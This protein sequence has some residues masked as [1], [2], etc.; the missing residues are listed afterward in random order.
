MKALIKII[1]GLLLLVVLLVGG[2][3]VAL[4]TV[5]PNAYKGQL[6]SAVKE[7]TGRDLSIGG[8]ISVAFYPVLGF[9]A[10]GLE[11][12]NPE[13]FSGNDFVKAGEVQ[14][15]VNIMPLLKKKIEITTVRLVEPQI[16][17]IKNAD[18]KTNL[19]MPKKDVAAKAETPKLD[20]SVEGIEVSKA[21]VIYIDKATGKTT[22]INPLNLKIP[23]YASGRDIDV[24]LDMVVQNSAPAKPMKF[25]LSATVKPDLGKGE[26]TLRN[27]RANIDMGGAKASVTA[28]V[29]VNTKSE[30]IRISNLETDWQDTS[31]KGNATVKGFKEPAVTFD[32]SSPSVD[33]D[34]LMP[35]KPGQAKD[36]NKQL[37]PVDVLRKLSLDGKVAI[38]SLKTAGL[39]L[40]NVSVPVKAKGGIINLNPLT[41]NMY[42]GALSSHIQIDARNNAPAFSLKGDLKALEMGKLLTAK[43]GQDYLTGVTNV[44]F[45]LNSR[46]NTMN[47]LN[48]HSGGEIS[49]DFGKGY[50][51]KWQLSRLLNQAIAYFET[52]KLDQAADDKVYFTSLDGTFSGQG[53][54]FR[55]DNLVLIGP[56]SHALGSGSVNLGVQTVDYVVRVGGGDN[57]EKFAKKK[58]LPVRMTGP[59][60]K[61]SYSIDMQALIQ[62]VAG[63]K[64]EEKKQELMDGLF[65]KLDK[66]M[67]K[68]T[69]PTAAAPEAG[70]VTET[71]PAPAIENAPVPVEA[72]PTAEPAPAAVTP[73]AAPAEPVPAETPA[74]EAPENTPAEAVPAETAPAEVAPDAAAP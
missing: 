47:A 24:V 51:N 67:N 29:I 1:L 34:A 60:S 57:P 27:A 35:K 30:E 71:T 19:E 46:G 33:L 43:M 22:T 69:E 70:T 6:S 16:T 48:S 61:P 66:K 31:I 28:G 15:G 40:T 25:D 2:A 20:M 32:V 12:G 11:I 59:F 18:G 41:L 65:K 73:D 9:K 7:A 44:A 14:A 39:T 8:D 23:S 36:N 45:D 53:G 72:A 21:K 49:F 5:D 58:H 10:A 26:F 52:G 68:T 38:G 13:G 3:A 4:M 55:N 42:D 74:A 37:L 17:V 56:K 64:I 50:I 62:D 54:V 63:E